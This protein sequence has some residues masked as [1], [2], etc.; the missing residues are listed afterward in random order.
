MSAARVWRPRR[1]L[2][3][4]AGFGV[5]AVS[6]GAAAAVGY[7]LTRLTALPT[8]HGGGGLRLHLALIAGIAIVSLAP[9]AARAV[10]GRFDALEPVVLSSLALIILF[11]LR[12]LV[13]LHVKHYDFL[14]ADLTSSYGQALAAALT[15][16]SAFMAAYHL[17]VGARLAERTPLI[18]ARPDHLKVFN[19]ALL[20]LLGTLAVLALVIVLSGGVTALVDMRHQ[21]TLASRVPPVLFESIQVAVPT[22]LLF[23]VSRPGLPTLSALAAVAAAVVILFMSVPMGNR[24]YLLLFIVSAGAWYFIRRGRRPKLLPTAA[25]ALVLLLLVAIPVRESRKGTRTFTA[26][27]QETVAAPGEAL[28]SPFTSGDTEQIDTLAILVHDLGWRVPFQHGKQFLTNN[29]LLPV[30]SEVWSGKPQKIRTLI[31]QARFGG[32][33][34]NCVAFCPTFSMI[35]DF[36]SD[37]GLLS[38]AVGA[39][40]VGLLLRFSYAYLRRNSHDAI[41]KAA[42]CANLWTAFYIWWD[43]YAY[44][45][46]NAVLLVCPFVIAGLWARAGAAE[47]DPME[48]A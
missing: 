17:P 18:R 14:G 38:V 40:M 22:L 10:R 21:A 9:L 6:L 7:G 30:P 48:R 44:L 25:I 46:Q 42:Y 24:R 4:P 45:V 41:V 26:A 32:R 23:R 39:A 47:N 19:L 35:G 43:S 3:L 1:A 5:A 36:Y 28:L 27:L 16:A 12:P 13:D 11:V 33:D 15:A 34:G 37:F 31:I 2:S 8:A 20:M 29:L